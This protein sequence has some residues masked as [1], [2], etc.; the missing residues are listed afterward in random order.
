[1]SLIGTGRVASV[2]F[3]TRW[4]KRFGRQSFWAGPVHW[5]RCGGGGV[6]ACLAGMTRLLGL[7]TKKLRSGFPSG[8]RRRKSRSVFPAPLRND[9]QEEVNA[10]Q[11]TAV[12]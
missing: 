6:P 2:I 10:V 9:Q 11:V 5:G 4:R 3:G 8:E 1:M 12:P 7:R